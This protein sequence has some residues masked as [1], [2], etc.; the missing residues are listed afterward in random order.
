MLARFCGR[1]LWLLPFFLLNSSI[2]FAQQTIEGV[3]LET[4][5]T[6]SIRTLKAIK[7]VELPLDLSETLKLVINF[8]EKC[9]NSYKDKRKWSDKKTDCKFHNNNLIE[10]IYY[11]DI[12]NKKSDLKDHYL[13]LRHGYN[14]GSFIYF[15][16]ITIDQKDKEIDVRQ[17]LLSDEEVKTFLE[18]KIET[19][20][21]FQGVDSHF[22]LKVT[23]PNKT[24]LTFTYQSSTDHWLLNKEM[25]IGE[26]FESTAKGIND[27]FLSFSEGMKTP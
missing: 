1:S 17:R 5:K 21:S 27:L 4:S 22:H 24:Q 8:E 7:S 14:R 16:E 19:L 12:K 10:T 18:T 11:R 9:N 6:K 25:M 26:I 2:V 15:E 23:D 13:L 20:F 3:T